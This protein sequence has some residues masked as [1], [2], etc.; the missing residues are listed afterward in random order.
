VS[1]AKLQDLRRR[2]AQ[3]DQVKI[4]VR[5]PALVKD[6]AGR[7]AAALGVEVAAY[8]R[9]AIARAVAEDLVRLAP[10][11]EADPV[12]A[13]MPGAGTRGRH[14][15]RVRVP[16][17][18]TWAPSGQGSRAGTPFA[19]SGDALDADADAS[20]SKSSGAPSAGARVPADDDRTPEEVAEDEALLARYVASELEAAEGRGGV[21]NPAALSKWLRDDALSN[22]EKVEAWL[23][24]QE[25][26]PTKRRPGRDPA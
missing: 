7:I 24:R 16:E 6:A 19:L 5:V 26:A 22:P 15:S 8:A 9:T 1:D 4:E 17:V 23:E 13:H 25:R 20:S 12:P 2:A 11:L 10:I 18:G 14:V 21:R 3:A